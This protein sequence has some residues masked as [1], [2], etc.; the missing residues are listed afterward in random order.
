MM[1]KS[2][3]ITL[4]LVAQVALGLPRQTITLQPYAIE[5]G[6]LTVSGISAGAAMA[7]QFHVAFS[8]DVN[9]VG[10][11]AGIPYGCA[12]STLAGALNCM[13]SP[14]LTSVPT[15]IS[16][17]DDYAQQGTIDPTSNLAGDKVYVF[18]G[19]RD[20]T[21]NNKNGEQIVTF[22]ENYLS[23]S[24]ITTEF[25]I[26]AEHCQPTD[27][28]GEVCNKQNSANYINDCDYRGAYL[29]LNHFYGGNLEPGTTTTAPDSN[30]FLFDQAEFFGG[31]PGSYSMDST[32]YVYIP[33]MCQDPTRYCKLH[34]VLHG[35]LQSSKEIGDV[36]VKNAGYLEVAEANGIILLFPQ[37]VA[38]AVSNPNSCFDWWGYADNNYEVQSGVQMDGIYQMVKR[39]GL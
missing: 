17:A 6:S 39:L 21:V 18:H 27:N 29:A 16:R 5:P 37:A 33:T 31:R 13:S 2:V 38:T 4:F 35:C 22:Y 25:T 8:K 1:L 23:A 11:F 32:G 20:S 9:G 15:L 28:F 19:T 12:K 7:S 34:V 24:D 10:I 26:A 36:F 30:L 3:M 14:F